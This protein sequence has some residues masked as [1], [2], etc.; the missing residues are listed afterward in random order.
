MTSRTEPESAKAVRLVARAGRA[1]AVERRRACAP[2]CR[3]EAMGSR[4]PRQIMVVGRDPVCV[5][6]QAPPIL[7]RRRPQRLVEALDRVAEV[8][9]TVCLAIG[10]QELRLL[11]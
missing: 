6:V 8:G 4:G 2:D 7:S 5:A 1:N 3:K 10:A 11:P 9:A